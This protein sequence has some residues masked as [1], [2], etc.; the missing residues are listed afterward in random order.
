MKRNIIFAGFG[1]IAV[2]IGVFAFRD[3]LPSPVPALNAQT[4]A[5]E[6]ASKE[7]AA[8]EKA[9]ENAQTVKD[10]SIGQ[11]DAPVSVVEYVAFTCPHCADFFHSSFDRLK[12]DYIDAGKVRF[13][14]REVYFN[15]YGL[16]AGMVARC[17]GDMRYFGLVDVLFE[18]QDEW[19]RAGDP[20]EIAA[21][22]KKIGKIAGLSD[23]QLDS[24]LQ[25]RE[26][27]KAMVELYRKNATEDEITA[28]PSFVVNG[29]VHPNMTYEDLKEIIDGLL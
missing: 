15:R 24:C 29:E 10:V 16:W 21:N 3:T 1:V 14:L 18:K 8:K 28:T 2:T 23:A 6:G 7:G 27:A 13:T 11:A 5:S 19:M 20:A 17:G 22:L 12:S 9:V 25:D 4:A 26:T